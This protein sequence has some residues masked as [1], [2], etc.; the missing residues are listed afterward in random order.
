MIGEVRG[1]GVFCALELVL[2]RVTREPVPAAF[3]ARIER[4]ALARN[5]SLADSRIHVVP[6][7]IITDDEARE[8]LAVIDGVLA[9][10]AVGA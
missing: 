3:L 10:A 1:L 4:V 2:D 7:C 9:E 6:S 5:L 8:G